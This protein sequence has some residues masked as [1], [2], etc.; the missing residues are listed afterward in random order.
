MPVRNSTRVDAR[1]PPFCPSFM[2]VTLKNRVTFWC[3]D[4]R[5]RPGRSV[6]SGAALPGRSA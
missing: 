3:G 5:G 6:G 1:P 4:W 2:L